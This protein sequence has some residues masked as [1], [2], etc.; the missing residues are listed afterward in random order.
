MR[1][2]PLSLA[3]LFC[4][5]AHQAASAQRRSGAAFHV[6]LGRHQVNGGLVDFR[7][8]AMADVLAAFP[9]R[10]KSRW[11]LVGAIGAGAVFGGFGDRCLLKPGGGCAEKANFTTFN[12]LVGGENAFGTGAMRALVGPAI[13]N[14]AGD[15]SLGAQARVDLSVAIIARLG[16]GLMARATFLPSHNGQSLTTWAAGGSVSFR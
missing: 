8:G 4:L 10:E 9:L 16:V 14:G 5:I 2:S 6:T 1:L 12:A 3:T 11:N 13:Y 7:K 15:T